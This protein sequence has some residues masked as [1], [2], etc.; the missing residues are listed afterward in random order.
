VALKAPDRVPV[1]GVEC[2]RRDRHLAVVAVLAAH[3]L[4]RVPHRRA[5]LLAASAVAVGV[6]PSGDSQPLHWAE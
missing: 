1:A 3:R 4:S 2:V 6:G 5:L